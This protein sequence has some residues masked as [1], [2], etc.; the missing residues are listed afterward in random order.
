MIRGAG[1][2]AEDAQS[3]ESMCALIT[4]SA[5]LEPQM[6]QEQ[7]FDPVAVVLDRFGGRCL[8]ARDAGDGFLRRNLSI[9]KAF[10]LTLYS[11]RCGT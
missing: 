8:L 6:G 1:V 11:A 7:N 9:K 4:A 10:V 5:T 2:G 3:E